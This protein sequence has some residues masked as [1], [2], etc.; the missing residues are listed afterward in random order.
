[1]RPPAAIVLQAR[2]ELDGIEHIAQWFQH[3]GA[4]AEDQL[5][6]LIGGL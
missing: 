6:M 2:P 5:A 4:L 1:M 3:A